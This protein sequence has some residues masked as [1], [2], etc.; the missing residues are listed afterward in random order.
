MDFIDFQS[1]VIDEPASIPEPASRLSL[2]SLSLKEDTHV[3]SEFVL[4]AISNGVLAKKDFHSKMKE[5]AEISLNDLHGTVISNPGSISPITVSE[6]KSPLQKL[7]TNQ[8]LSKKIN[9]IVNGPRYTDHGSDSEMRQILKVFEA[10]EV[11][12]DI[13]YDQLLKPDFIGSLTRKSL[14]SKLE[15]YMLSSHSKTLNNFQPIARRIK[16]L[17]EPLESI[18]YVMNELDVSV[19]VTFK[20]N[21]VIEKLTVLK[22]KR[23]VMLKLRDS[24]SLTQVELDHLQNGSIDADFFQIF[25]KANSIKAKATYLF[26]NEETTAAGTALVDTVNSILQISNKRIYNYLMDFMEEYD[27]MCKRFGERTI[28]DVNLIKFQSGLVYLSNDLQLFQDFLARIVTLRSKRL[29]D[30]FLSQFDMDNRKLS[31]PIILSAH[32]PVRYLGDVLAY[33]HSLIVNEF[34]FLKSLFEI[35]SELVTDDSILKDNM[36]FVTDLNL[37]LL[38]QL[39]NILSNT[40]RIRLEQIVRF[41]DD[42]L[43]NL[44]IIQCL[45]LYQIMFTKNGIAASAQLISTLGDLETVA[46]DKVVKS[47]TKFL[48]HLDKNQLTPTDLLPPDWFSDYLSKLCQVL[49]KLDKIGEKKILTKEFYDQLITE[50]LVNQITEYLQ[51]WFPSAKKELSSKI[52]LLIVQIN[53]FDLLQSRLSISKTSIFSTK[54]GVEIYSNIDAKFIDSTQKLQNAM[55]RYLFTSTGL[56]LY[57]N[58]FNMIFPIDSVEDDLDH[59]MYLSCIENPIMNLATIRENVQSKLHDYLPLAI[60]DFQEVM[61]SNLVSPVVEEDIVLVCFRNFSRFYS[62]FQNVLLKLYPEDSE[63]V[64]QIL[65]F[66]PSEVITLLGIAM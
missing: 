57:Y 41:E 22:A 24:L 7:T 51:T 61:L 44:D 37:K 65:V 20:F 43:I 38:N 36:D 42:P 63:S 66:T 49:S 1:Y 12:L 6:P 46:R 59:E 62:I 39:F 25:Q 54:Y 15:N 5:Y 23:L 18:T 9:N 26:S 19:D 28:N 56:E 2:A 13:N 14:N 4:P 3:P 55:N 48:H 52:N 34:E 35:R 33:V 60:T 50:P 40:I 31:K 45:S 17:S 64:R 27:D 16:R 30:D 58:L 29:L 32:D 53:C 10:N 11:N 8:V 47:L 21:P